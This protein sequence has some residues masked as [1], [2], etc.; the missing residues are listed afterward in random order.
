MEKMSLAAALVKAGLKLPGES[1]GAFG[2]EIKKLNDADR[3]WFKERFAKEM[4]LEIVE[5]AGRI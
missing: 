4:G 2:Q 1:V 3:E 5:V